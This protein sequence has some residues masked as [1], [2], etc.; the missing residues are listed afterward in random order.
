MSYL[1]LIVGLAA[2]YCG[3]EWFLRYDAPL[4]RIG[5]MMVAAA[6]VGMTVASVGSIAE[7]L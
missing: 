5:S 3:S 2:A 4:A 1:T 6:G 7:G